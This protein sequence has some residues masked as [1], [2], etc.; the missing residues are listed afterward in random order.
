VTPSASATCVLSWPAAQRRT[1]RALIA[2]A[3]AV[4]GRRDH[5]SSRSRSLGARKT[6]STEEVSRKDAA[7]I[8][9]VSLA[10]IDRAIAIRSE[11]RLRDAVLRGEV[12]LRKAQ[13]QARAARECEPGPEPA[14]EAAPAPVSLS[15]LLDVSADGFPFWSRVYCARS[16]EVLGDVERPDL[17]LTDP[18]YGQG[19]GSSEEHGEMLGDADMATGYAVLRLAIQRLKVGGIIYCFGDPRRPFDLQQAGGPL[20]R[21]LRPLAWDM[22]TLGQGDCTDPW[23]LSWEYISAGQ[24]LPDPSS[25]EDMA[26][27]RRIYESVREQDPGDLLP[28]GCDDAEREALRKLF[29]A[30]VTGPASF[31]SARVETLLRLVRPSRLRRGAVLRCPRDDRGD[32]GHRTVK[33]VALL[34]ELIGVSSRPYD[35]MLDPF[36]GSGATGV[37]AMRLG[38]RFLG[39]EM[40]PKHARTAARRIQSACQEVNPEDLRRAA[41]AEDARWLSTSKGWRWWE[42][43][44]AARE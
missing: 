24:R 7:R 17:L 8:A 36:A 39:V 41:L 25:A 9:G 23:G 1:I 28:P 42:G 43:I 35:L 11:P 31:D 38:R 21:P 4:L 22:A 44:D 13:A 32:H 16:Q 12:S 26:E 20:V 37:A 40:D 30:P 6:S 18:P 5:A 10:T 2:K 14:P 29:G 27:L 34:E 33:P 19:T 3:C 15:P